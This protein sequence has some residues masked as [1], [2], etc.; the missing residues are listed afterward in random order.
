MIDVLKDGRLL[1]TYENAKKAVE[2][3]E[4]VIRFFCCYCLFLHKRK[5]AQIAY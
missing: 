1:V 4:K 5:T 2:N 3:I